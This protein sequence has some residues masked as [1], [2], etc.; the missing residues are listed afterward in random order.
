MSDEREIQTPQPAFEPATSDNVDG[1]GS[2]APW[3]QHYVKESLGRVRSAP[4][5]EAAQAQAAIEQVVLLHSIRNLLVWTLI[6]VPVLL[7]ALG[8]VFV[9]IGSSSGS[10]SSTSCPYTTV[11]C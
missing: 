1:I 6:I 7:L 4:T 9:V 11:R 2:G 8:V 10:S 5:V 3:R